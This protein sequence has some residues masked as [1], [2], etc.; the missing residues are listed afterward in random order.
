MNLLAVSGVGAWVLL[1]GAA[2]A[3]IAF[4]ALLNR[5]IDRRKK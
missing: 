3:G 4:G 1:I 2:I 5:V